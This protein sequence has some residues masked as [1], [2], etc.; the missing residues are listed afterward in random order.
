MIQRSVR[1]LSA[2]A[3]LL[4]AQ[5]AHAQ[6]DAEEAAGD[7]PAATET[8]A[9][10]DASAKAS[11]GVGASTD[12]S[13]KPNA[14][15][16]EAKAPSTEQAESAAEDEGLT[17]RWKGWSV[18]LY[19]FAALNVMH[20]ST[21]SFG[22]A[23]G[24]TI[25]QR[26]GTFR[27]NHN[28][29][30]FTARDSRFGL[31][32]N[33]PETE[34]V[35][36][37]ATVEAD[38]G[39]VLPTEVNEQTSFTQAPLRMRHYYLAAKTPIVDLLAG[40]YHD[41]FGWG[42][43][44]FYPST[45]AFLGITGEIYHRQPQFRVS[46]T[47]GGKA[48]DF[49]M[50][51]AAARPVQKGSGIPDMEAG[52]RLAINGWKGIGQQGYG[53]PQLNPLSVGVSGIGRRFE[54]A[55]FVEFPGGS[56]T[57]NGWGFAANAFLP[58][59]PAKSAKDRSNALSITGEFSTG[60]GISDMYNGDLTGGALFPVLPNPQQRSQPDNP[61]PI[62]PQNID[63][64]I[65]TYDANGKLQTIDWQGFVVGAQ[66]YLPVLQGRIWI[67]GNY[68]QV[69]SGNI[70]KLTPIPARSS[71]YSKAQYIDGNLFVGLT[72]QLQVGYSFQL[73]QQTFGDGVEAK[74]Y[75]NEG[76]F[77]FFF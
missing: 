72:D 40:Q 41:L 76:A 75:R 17:A 39:A 71:V 4:L 36:A 32:I 65:V 29:L 43:S 58:V 25:L 70:V 63:S 49:E 44:G 10:S 62:F 18:Q 42:G 7:K 55:Q 64:G 77:H 60:T 52:L 14:A 61:P 8:E 66:Y 69:K 30:Q 20:D 28:Q 2:L 59:I 56:N 23:S 26:V 74:N 54:V 47:V 12:A 3:T 37:S 67:S 53:R 5:A 22:T 6:G 33:A 1:S 73:V 31:H 34:W 46:K 45:I 38:F 24:N 19:G 9:S 50:A 68:S 21:Q 51:V 13:A 57:A 11:V 27:G 16:A 35:K 15:A 48:V